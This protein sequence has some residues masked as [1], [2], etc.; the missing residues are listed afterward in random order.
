MPQTSNE[1]DKLL[2][3]GLFKVFNDR[4][5]Y[6]EQSDMIGQVYNVIT[7]S[8]KAVE[9]VTSVGQVSDVQE[10]TGRMAELDIA[11]GWSTKFEAKQFGGFLETERTLADD[12]QYGVFTLSNNEAGLADSSNRGR[13]DNAA[14]PI[15][16][17]DS[18]AFDFI[19]NQEEGTALASNSHKTKALNV[20]TSTGFDNLGTSSLSKTAT[21][22]TRILMRKTKTNLGRRFTS[23]RRWGLLVPDTQEFKAKEINNTPW[24]LDSGQRN[25]NLQ[26]GIYEVIVWE[27][28]ED[29]SSNNWAMVDLNMMKMMMMFFDRTKGETERE[30]DFMTKAIRQ[31]VY[32]R[33]S[34]GHN[35]WRFIFWQNVD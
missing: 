29:F 14:R 9:E 20:S 31:S 34:L 21:A 16:L 11:P 3:E 15:A 2:F 25:E 28:L 27:R 24:G 23:N 7:N 30:R 17:A 6:L 5:T 8:T 35:D 22:A 1:F 26:F 18:A 32:D 13:E 12:E 33:Y 10:F 4:M 19:T